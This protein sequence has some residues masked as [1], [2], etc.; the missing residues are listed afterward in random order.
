MN[1]FQNYMKCYKEKCVNRLHTQLY[2]YK[3]HC[4]IMYIQLYIS[5]LTQAASSAVILRSSALTKDD[6]ATVSTPDT[7]KLAAIIN[8]TVSTDVTMI[9]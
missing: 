4:I 8:S 7:N 6:W 3:A 9:T 2:K 5:V 1:L